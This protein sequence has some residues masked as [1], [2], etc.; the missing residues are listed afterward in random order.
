MNG[1]NLAINPSVCDL[2]RVHSKRWLGDV[3]TQEAW[4]L[5]RDR[6]Y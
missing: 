1:M 3:N 6:R 5:I 4:S 2:I